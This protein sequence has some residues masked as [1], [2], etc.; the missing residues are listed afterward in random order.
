MPIILNK[1]LYNAVKKEADD[2]YDKPSAYKSG[3]IVKRYKELGG[4]YEDD[5]EPKNLK[6]WFKEEWSSIGGDYPTYRPTK[7]ITKDTP[8]TASEIDPKQAKE[9]IKLKQQYKG[10]KNLPPFKQGGVLVSL[11]QPA[12]KIP[13]QDEVYKYS[14]PEKVQEKANE[15]L[16]KDVIV[17]RSTK[18]D[19]KYMVFNPETDKL[20]HFGQMGYEDFTKHQDEKRRQN[21]LRR[22]ANM[23]GNWKD[24]KYSANNLSRNILW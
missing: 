11:G 7:R 6:R 10:E 18:K 13:K 3:W 19:K 1:K 8:L 17:Y 21:Y 23:K 16:G 14:N 24:N 22:T 12:D 9:Q 15:Y 5:N 2:I 20:I 4:K